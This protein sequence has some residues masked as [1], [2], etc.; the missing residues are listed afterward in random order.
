[1]VL[2][3]K[4]EKMDELWGIRVGAVGHYKETA[5]VNRLL[6]EVVALEQ[7]PQTEAVA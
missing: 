1:M 5:S 4:A 7:P 3:S 2:R 6:T